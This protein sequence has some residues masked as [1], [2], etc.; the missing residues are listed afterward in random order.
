MSKNPIE[1]ALMGCDIF[2]D[3][4]A[5]EMVELLNTTSVFVC[6]GE[7]EPLNKPL[8]PSTRHSIED[9]PNLELKALPSHLKYAFLSDDDTLPTIL[10]ASLSDVQV[11]EALIVHK[12]RKKAIGCKYQISKELIL[13]SD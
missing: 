12:R 7:F 5:Y 9:T 3:A 13:E 2:G 8:G 4:K 11:R 1:R 6:K 10:S